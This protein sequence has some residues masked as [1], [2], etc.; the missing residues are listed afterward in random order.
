MNK[1]R[2]I[3]FGSMAIL[4]IVF[5]KYL[6]FSKPTAEQVMADFFASEWRAEE[7]NMDPLILNS[8]IVAPLVIEYVKNK[9]MEL[10]RYAIGF[11]GNEKIM[12][13]LPVLRAILADE[14]EKEYFRADALEAIFKI[15]RQ[16]GLTLAQLHNKR[17]DLLGY[18]ARGLLSGEHIPFHRTYAE[19]LI[20]YKN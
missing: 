2:W 6:L 17:A 10:R 4:S 3:V 9:E 15:G 5:M 16:E 12:D 18:I 13:S 14:T 8:D 20:G 11:L 7:M 1:R 19:A